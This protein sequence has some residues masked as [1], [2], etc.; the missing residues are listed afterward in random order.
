M[1]NTS[2]QLSPLPRRPAAG[3]AA[4]LAVCLLWAP[5][6]TVRPPTLKLRDIEVAAAD[7]KKLDLVLE[8][9]VH[10]PND[11]QISL[12]AFEYEMSAAGGTLASGALDRPVTP[13]AAGKTVVVR[14]PVT[15]EFA[16]LAG[17]LVKAVGGESI[18]YELACRA[19]FDFTAFKKHVPFSHAGT[20]PAL[21]AP[22]W[23]FRDVRWQPADA[24]GPRVTLVFEVTNPN[25]FALP[26]RKLSG[27]LMYGDQPLVHVEA[28]ALKPVPAEASAQVQASAKLDAAEAVKALLAGLKDRQALRFEGRLALDVPPAL[29]ELLL[30]GKEGG[31]E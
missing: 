2:R 5:G 28:G 14:A 8:F 16:A 22:S 3:W 15:L 11:Y 12:H 9:A 19:T 27:A 7:F 18:D 25:R 29:H 23:R 17:P 13:L 20:L 1:T 26:L 30:R 31:H 4:L 6:C 24:G 10:N 21:R